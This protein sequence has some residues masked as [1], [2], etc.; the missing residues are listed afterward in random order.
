MREK[1]TGPNSPLSII[2]LFSSLAEIAS[3][4]AMFALPTHL[5]EIFIWFIMG[6]PA[7]LILGFFITLNLNPRVLYAP[8]DFKDENNYMDSI[9]R[10]EIKDSL[11]SLHE[12]VLELQRETISEAEKVLTNVGENEAKK[13]KDLTLKQMET[14]RQRIEITEAR[15]E[16]TVSNPNPHESAQIEGVS[17]RIL[18][19]LTEGP[20]RS[21]EI[22]K[23]VGLSAA[24]ITRR[25]AVMRSQGLIESRALGPNLMNELTPL[26][27]KIVS[28]NPPFATSKLWA[29]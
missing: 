12:R 18:Q 4:T 3:T 27:L 23:N 13:I 9:G 19:V 2:A 21:S 16:E 7:A 14:I 26:G 17:A 10:R 1:I 11:S 20:Q 6:F 28:F 25:L 15:I 8:S 5:Q 22:A 24:T 29:S